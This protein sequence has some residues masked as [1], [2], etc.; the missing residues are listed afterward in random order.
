[1]TQNYLLLGLFLV[2]QRVLRCQPACSSRQRCR[3]SQYIHRHFFLADEK[4]LRKVK[5]R[6]LEHT[7]QVEGDMRQMGTGRRTA[8]LGID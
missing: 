6:G 2:L 8:A 7:D 1:M 5:A 4:R 3:E